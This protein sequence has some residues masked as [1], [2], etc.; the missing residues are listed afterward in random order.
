M[1]ATGAAAEALTNAAK[2]GRAQRVVVFADIDEGGGLF[3]TIK[4]DGTGFDVVGVR[5][6]AG[7]A[8]SIRGRLDQVGG[9]VEF[10]SAGGEGAEVRITYPRSRSAEPPVAEAPVLSFGTGV[11]R[12]AGRRPPHGAGRD[13][14]RPRAA[15]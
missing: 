8:S 5:E 1:A 12:R 4:D 9:G 7:M 2:H 15:L 14:C 6:G 10:A 3:L 11:P 13:P